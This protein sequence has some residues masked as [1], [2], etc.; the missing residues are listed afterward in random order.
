MGLCCQLHSAGISVVA[1]SK[2]EVPTY[3]HAKDVQR[4]HAGDGRTESVGAL[5]ISRADDDRGH[6]IEASRSGV[7]ES[8]VRELRLRADIVQAAGCAVDRKSTRLNSS[9]LVISYAV[10][11]LKKTIQV[12]LG[13]PLKLIGVREAPDDLVPFEPTEFVAALF[14]QRCARQWRRLSAQQHS[15]SLYCDQ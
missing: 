9:H 13:I 7:C 8:F 3:V 15:Q 11:C 4:T 14:A 12:D 5:Q 10:F 2:R 6:A 1:A